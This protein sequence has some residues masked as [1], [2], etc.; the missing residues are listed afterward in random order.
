MSY[1]RCQVQHLRQVSPGATYTHTYWP[2]IVS[3]TVQTYERPLLDNPCASWKNGAAMGTYETL[4]RPLLFLL[5]PERA[6]AAAE[7]LL[8]RGWLWKLASSYLDYGDSRLHITAAGLEFP[9]PVGLAAGYDKN[10][11]FLSGLLGLGFGY[12]VGGTVVPEA[13]AGNPKPRVARLRSQQSL[14]NSLGF[15]SKGMEA[16]KRNLERLHE[17]AGRYPKPIIASVAGLSLEEFQAC[18][19]T[20]EPLADA[21]EL[22]ISSPNTKGLRIFQEPDTFKTLVE[23]INS[24]RSKPIFI[25][26]PPYDDDQ[27]QER[28][29]G[30]VRIARGLGVEGITATNTR[31][32]DAPQLAMGQGGLSGR[33]L[34]E[35]TVRIVPEVRAEMGSSAAINACGGISTAADALRAL[36]AG[37]NTV[38]LL[39]GLIYRG[40]GVARSINRGLVK[41]MQQ[42]GCASLTELVASGTS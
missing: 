2:L 4:L 6:Q 29:L 1:Q 12:V 31:T 32:V 21:T 36:Q 17:K 22:N 8:K 13:R 33:S 30:L 11:E 20:V 28:V 34:L 39:T 35:D 15:P 24:Q 19:A 38:Q 26:I 7:W 37:A 18:H 40:P 23:R 16:A 5:P 25:K 41:L 3:R 27:G 10:C 42:Q 14:I 9:T